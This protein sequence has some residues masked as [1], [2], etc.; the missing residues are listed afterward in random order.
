[1]STGISMRDIYAGGAGTGARQCGNQRQPL[2]CWLGGRP[3]GSAG[4][5]PGNGGNGSPQTLSVFLFF[6]EVSGDPLLLLPGRGLLLC[7]GEVGRARQWA[8]GRRRHRLSST[9]GRST[10][11]STGTGSA[12]D[13]AGGPADASAQKTVTTP[14]AVSQQASAKKKRR[15]NSSEGSV[16]S[17]PGLPLGGGSG[18]GC[19]S[20]KE[21]KRESFP[22]IGVFS[23]CPAIGVGRPSIYTT[24]SGRR[25]TVESLVRTA[26]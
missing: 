17:L 18:G 1:M 14:G 15:R 6:G 5:A 13:T 21:R 23:G 9:N 19:R 26:P 8:Q 24:V 25:N 7:A 20:R 11:Q 10:G 3:H 2:A 12:T 4:K 22:S 16:L